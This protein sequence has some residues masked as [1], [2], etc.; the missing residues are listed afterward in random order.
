[1]KCQLCGEQIKDITQGAMVFP[2][3]ETCG[4]CIK[5]IKELKKSRT[6]TEKENN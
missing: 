2:W 6:L 3:G 5:N 4:N 1:M